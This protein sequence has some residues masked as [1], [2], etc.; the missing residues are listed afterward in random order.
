VLAD[1]GNFL[2]PFCATPKP[3]RKIEAKVHECADVSVWPTLA[4]CH[5]PFATLVRPNCLFLPGVRREKK[6]QT[7]CAAHIIILLFRC[8]RAIFTLY[9]FSFFTSL[10]IFLGDQKR[11]AST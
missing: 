4:E 8:R 5:A 1:G 10:Q 3:S 6:Q 7:L 11:I 9:A 2:A